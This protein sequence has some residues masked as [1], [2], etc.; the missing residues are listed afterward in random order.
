MRPTNRS[1]FYQNRTL[2]V[3]ELH[4]LLA[5]VPVDE[6]ETR[7]RPMVLGIGLLAVTL[8][9]IGMGLALSS[10]AGNKQTGSMLLLGGVFLGLAY[11]LLL[12]VPP[13][14]QQLNRFFS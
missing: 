8:S 4:D 5:S 3:Q 9:S 6:E 2:T 14:K 12:L 11:L 1:S 10:E 7:P 13:K